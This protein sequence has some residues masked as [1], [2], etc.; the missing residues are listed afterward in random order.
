MSIK[1]E[2]AQ[3]EQSKRDLKAAKQNHASKVLVRN[4]RLL[5]LA[6]VMLIVV[7]VAA[8]IYGRIHI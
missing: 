1:Q 7:I 5:K 6:V 4:Y 8:F 3:I 2:K